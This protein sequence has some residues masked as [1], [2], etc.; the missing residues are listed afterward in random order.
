MY[1]YANTNTN[2]N[3][4]AIAMANTKTSPHANITNLTADTDGNTQMTLI[5]KFKTT[6]DIKTLE[7]SASERHVST[8]DE[9]AC[10][11]KTIKRTRNI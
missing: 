9:A 2:A 8:C 3:G 11:G 1:T 4:N 5:N 10:P 6:N 7:F